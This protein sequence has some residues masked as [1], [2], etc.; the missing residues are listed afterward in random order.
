AAGPQGEQGERGRVGESA[1]VHVSNASRSECP[2]G[3]EVI[4]IG[5][6]D[7]LETVVVC[8]GQDGAD[9]TAGINGADG[10]DGPAGADGAPGEPGM[11]GV[12]PEATADKIV[13]AVHCYA[14]LDGYIGADYWFREFASGAVWASAIVSDGAFSASN[15]NY[16]GASQEGVDIATVQLAFDLQGPGFG[17][18]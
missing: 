9:G 4:E 1:V 7:E 3:G 6:G 14:R 16:Y 8:N 17:G 12:S 2:A 5:T 10:E 13:S 18:R 15:S 11:D